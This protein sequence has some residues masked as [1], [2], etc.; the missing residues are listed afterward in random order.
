MLQLEYIPQINNLNDLYTHGLF[1]RPT[2]AAF[3][4]GEEQKEMPTRLS[5][6]KRKTDN[7]SVKDLVVELYGYDV[8]DYEIES[9][10]L[11]IYLHEY[12]VATDSFIKSPVPVYPL[13]MTPEVYESIMNELDGL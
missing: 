9:S 12:H 7:G 1:I 2:G 11:M 13:N 3:Q 8:Y 4:C 10:W 6:I 5:L